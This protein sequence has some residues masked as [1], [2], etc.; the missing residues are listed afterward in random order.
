[1]KKPG[2]GVNQPRAWGTAPRRYGLLAVGKGQA[3][4][5]FRVV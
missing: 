1:M 5:G 2:A 3:A 4:C